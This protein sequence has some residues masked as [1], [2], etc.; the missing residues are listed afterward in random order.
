L[1]SPDLKDALSKQGSRAEVLDQDDDTGGKILPSPEETGKQT[2]SNH[3]QIPYW[4]L[5]LLLWFLL[6]RTQRPGYPAIKIAAHYFS[7][8]PSLFALDSGQSASLGNTRK[9]D[10]F[11]REG[12]EVTGGGGGGAPLPSLSSEEPAN[13]KQEQG[14][15]LNQ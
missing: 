3:F 15:E 5:P 6:A 2:T 9:D 12:D 10:T 4:L 1:G 11:A 7:P 14:E 8:H 13:G